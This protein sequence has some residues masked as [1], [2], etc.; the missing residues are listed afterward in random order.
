[1]WI[2]Y[3]G[4]LWGCYQTSSS[5]YFKNGLKIRDAEKNP[6]CKF[7]KFLP[8]Q[9]FRPL[10]PWSGF[11]ESMATASPFHRIESA[12]RAVPPL[13]SLPPALNKAFQKYIIQI[14]RYVTLTFLS[15]TQQTKYTKRPPRRF[16]ASGM[17]LK[18]ARAAPVVNLNT[19]FNGRGL[20][21]SRDRA[22]GVFGVDLG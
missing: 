4:L 20:L 11:C 15:E 21:R 18:R 10:P 9:P 8:H 17:L 19:D 6:E 14:N 16:Q 1:M 7:L 22:A 5:L 13:W 3:P 2:S 12:V